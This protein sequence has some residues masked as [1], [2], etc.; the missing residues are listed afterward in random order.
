MR[1]QY[2][3]ISIS[4]ALFLSYSGKAALQ[5]DQNTHSSKPSDTISEDIIHNMLKDMKSFQKNLNE[6]LS[7]PPLKDENGKPLNS[8]EIHTLMKDVKEIKLK[9]NTLEEVM[10]SLTNSLGKALGSK[11]GI[12]TR[13]P[14]PEKARDQLLASSQMVGFNLAT[15]LT[16]LNQ[17]IE[18]LNN[19]VATLYR[20]SS[21]R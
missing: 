16:R 8:E 7:V 12:V 13:N 17:Q 19:H 20:S 18:I 1:C 5:S 21:Q 14:N 11:G 3:L 6:L 2:L 15:E 9:V 4:L 10:V